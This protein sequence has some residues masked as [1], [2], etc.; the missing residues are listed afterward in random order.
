MIPAIRRLGASSPRLRHIRRA[1][2]FAL[3]YLLVRFLTDKIVAVPVCRKIAGPIFSCAGFSLEREYL[4]EFAVV[5][6]VVSWTVLSLVV[7]RRELKLL[8]RYLKAPRVSWVKGVAIV[9]VGLI[10]Y[11]GWMAL[12]KMV[13]LPYCPNDRPDEPHFSVYTQPNYKPGSPRWPLMYI[14]SFLTV[15]IGEELLFRGVLFFVLLCW[16]GKWPAVLLSAF[17]FGAEHYN[18]WG[19]MG[20][21][22]TVCNTGFGVISSVIL[23]R[24]G[25]LRW[26][27]LFHSIFLAHVNLFTVHIAPLGLSF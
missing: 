23:L 12:V 26:C 16:V 18:Q 7:F 4:D 13:M 9:L 24:T 19:G 27:V 6:Q 21:A 8:K 25:R 20:W 14:Q 11:L 17:I 22:P 5:L 2:I 15:P 1:V 3:K 10:A